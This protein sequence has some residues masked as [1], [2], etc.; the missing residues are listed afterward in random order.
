[1]PIEILIIE[2][3][4]ADATLTRIAFRA[5][6]FTGGFYTVADGEEALAYVHQQNQYKDVSIPDL[7]LLAL[8]LPKVSGLE[9]LRAI[10]T[11][12]HLKHIPIIVVSGSQD[13]EQIKAVYALAN[14]FIRKTSDLDQFLELIESCHRFWGSVATLSPAQH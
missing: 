2:S 14:C 5:A 10:K 3:N 7:I 11:T 12:P 13:P 9:V 6:G 1:M 8:S 4:S